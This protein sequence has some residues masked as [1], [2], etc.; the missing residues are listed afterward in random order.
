MNAVEV[1]DHRV[2]LALRAIDAVSGQG[3]AVQ[4]V[5]DGQH[6]LCNRSGLW[7]LNRLRH[8]ADRLD[9][10]LRYEDG[11]AQPSAVVPGLPL[12]VLLQPLSR[13]HLPRRLRLQLPLADVQRVRDL[14]F[15]P[16]PSAPLALG[17]ALLR[18]S[19]RHAGAPLAHAVLSLHAGALPDSPLLGRGQS[20]ARGEAVVAVPGLPFWRAS[21][22]AQAFAREHTLQLRLVADPA[23]PLPPDPEA[24][25]QRQ[26]AGLVTHGQDVLLRSGATAFLS[27]DLP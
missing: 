19:L 13:A 17:W 8:P 26:G 12:A 7:V 11:F 22:G 27:L 18:L 10:L 21:G 1:L 25:A 4:P 16:S 15:Y 2:W 9:D 14:P 3:V 5:G 23:D 24:L 6:W 20:D